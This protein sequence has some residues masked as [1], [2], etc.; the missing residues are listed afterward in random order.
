[1]KKILW[2][3][4]F[5]TI[6]LAI[7]QKD[8]ISQYIVEEIVFRNYDTEVVANQY[9]KS[10]DFALFRQTNSFKPNGKEEF[11]DILYTVLNSGMEEFSFYCMFGYDE[12]INDFNNYIQNSEEVEAINNYIHPFNSFENISVT[13][14]NFNNITIEIDKI[15]S[16]D[17]I[18]YINEYINEFISEYI[19]SDMSDVEKI[20]IFHD[21]I[22]NNTKYDNDFELNTDKSTYPTHPYNAYGLLTENKAVCSGYSDVM[23]IFLNKIGIRNYKIASDE[24]VWNYVFVN[25]NWYHLDLTWDDPQT[26]NSSDLLIYDFF[27]ITTD[28][29]K[30][31]DV[32]K[33][34]YNQNLYLEAQ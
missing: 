8:L 10:N 30:E 19:N 20:K 22:I 26:S 15:Y 33:H 4:F 6:G 13:T 3:L 34:N 17:Q 23:A 18:K 5:I 27:L 24:H 29:L 11:N 32:E 12:C 28:E 14:N 16:D 7:W 2:V 25:N 1:M 21:Y 9:A 31:K